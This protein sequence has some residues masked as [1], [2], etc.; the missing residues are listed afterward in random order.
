MRVSGASA[1][2]LFTEIMTHS[3]GSKRDSDHKSMMCV[4]GDNMRKCF[5]KNALIIFMCTVLH[6]GNGNH[7]LHNYIICNYCIT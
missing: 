5:F 2:S 6:N 7:V 3:T 4:R 1:E